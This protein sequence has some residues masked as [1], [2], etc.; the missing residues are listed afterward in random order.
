MH[1][2]TN[3]RTLAW[4]VAVVALVFGVIGGTL[5]FLQD[6]TGVIENEFTYGDID[7]TLTEAVVDEYGTPA[8]PAQRTD[9]DQLYKLIPGHSYTKDPV[10]TV[11]ADSEA[12][13]IYL[14]IDNPISSLEDLTAGT[15]ASQMSTAGWSVLSTGTGEPV[16]VNGNPLSQT[17]TIYYKTAAS[18]NVDQDLASFTSLNIAA[19]ANVASAD[20][21]SI[22]VTAYAVQQDGFNSAMDAWR[23]TFGAGNGGQGGGGHEQQSGID[24]GID[25]LTG[26]AHIS[27]SR[28]SFTPDVS[29]IS[30]SNASQSDIDSVVISND[31]L[32]ITVNEDVLDDYGRTLTAT[33]SDTAGTNTET[34]RLHVQGNGGGGQGGD[35]GHSITEGYYDF[36]NDQAVFSMPEDWTIDTTS[37][38]WT[39][40]GVSAHVTNVTTNTNAN[41]HINELIVSFDSSFAQ[42]FDNQMVEATVNGT[43]QGQIMDLRLYVSEQSFGPMGIHADA[44]T[45]TGEAIIP[46]SAFSF[47]PSISTLD[48]YDDSS[49]ISSAV[50]SGDNL[51][52][53]VTASAL[54]NYGRQIGG[55]IS[56][57]NNENGENIYIH[58]VD[59]NNQGGGPQN[60]EVHVSSLNRTATID[61]NDMT[62]TPDVNNVARDFGDSSAMSEIDDIS[63]SNG[64]LNITLDSSAFANDAGGFSFIIYDTNGMDYAWIVMVFDTV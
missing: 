48:W 38:T 8:V 14:L 29:T 15:I 54:E 50:I 28:F 61:L 25:P 60:I 55:Y 43:Q 57:S 10:V 58:I 21:L 33:I 42:M 1:S 13:Y 7:I 22:D 56:D 32:V 26:E 35:Q 37:L 47:T 6:N 40:S 62:I 53:T 2:K 17:Q 31:E 36:A 16:R 41:E 3:K 20:N 19:N 11:T 24:T 59:P 4:I 45:S 63:I 9:R 12:G 18:S 30:W 39:T 49:A 23:A 34:I 51:V 27:L 5:A 64:N 46:L 52:V 44:D